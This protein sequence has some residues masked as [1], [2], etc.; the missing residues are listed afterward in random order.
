[1]VADM[2]LQEDLPR[3]L[4]HLDFVG[5]GLPMGSRRENLSLLSYQE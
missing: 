2:D 4:H 1:M 5:S 3:F